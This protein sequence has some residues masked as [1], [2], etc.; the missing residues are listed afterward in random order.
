M[1]RKIKGQIEDKRCN[2]MLGLEETIDQ[3]AEAIGARWHGHVW[4]NDNNNVL[5]EP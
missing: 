2:A 5:R 4:R 1:L 3:L